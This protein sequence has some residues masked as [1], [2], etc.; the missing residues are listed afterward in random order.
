MKAYGT[1]TL[2]A[3][4]IRPLLLGAITAMIVTGCGPTLEVH[5]LPAPDAQLHGR[6]TF[7]VVERSMPMDSMRPMQAA[8]GQGNGGT[9]GQRLQQFMLN[10]RI[11]DQKVREDISRAF[12][13]RG[14]IEDRERPDFEVFFSAEAV[15]VTDVDDSYNTYSHWYG[16]CCDVD[17]YTEATV[18]I[19]VVDPRT[20]E[21]LWRGGGE[22]RVSDNPAKYSRQLA[23]TIDAIV[24]KYPLVTLTSVAVGTGAREEA[25]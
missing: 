21:L 1:S 9:S 6:V 2:R 3:G 16:Y 11:I 17:D 5:N 18:V 24:A 4:A 12:A 13:A 7:R 20:G 25:R 15:E 8:E 14:Y 19:D 10:N 23:R 22:T